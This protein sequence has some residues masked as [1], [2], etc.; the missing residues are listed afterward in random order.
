MSGTGPA[1]A[2]AASL[3]LSTALVLCAWTLDIMAKNSSLLLQAVLAQAV[4]DPRSQTAADG[5]DSRARPA[6]PA[7]LVVAR[8]SHILSIHAQSRPPGCFKL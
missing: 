5:S 8:R 3:G 6:A 2:S 4:Y 7:A 1:C